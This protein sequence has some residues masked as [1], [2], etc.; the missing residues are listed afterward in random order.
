VEGI[1]EVENPYIV[2][3]A[4]WA[5]MDQSLWIKSSP[6]RCNLGVNGNLCCTRGACIADILSMEMFVEAPKRLVGNEDSIPF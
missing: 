1:V 4:L 2:T 6:L 5:I 3:S